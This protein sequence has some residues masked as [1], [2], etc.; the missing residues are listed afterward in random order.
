M[1]VTLNLNSNKQNETKV[2]VMSMHVFSVYSQLIAGV[3]QSFWTDP[4]PGGEER[5]GEERR[6]EERRG[7]ERPIG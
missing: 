1:Y 7:E 3:S 2:V 5:R 6:G 4:C